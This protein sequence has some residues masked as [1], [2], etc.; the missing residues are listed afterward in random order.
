MN[1]HSESQDLAYKLS[2]NLSRLLLELGKDYQRRILGRLHERG[3]RLFR[4]SHSSVFSNLGLGAVRVTELAERAQ[5]TQQAMGKMLKELERIGYI[6]RDVDSE[7]KRAKQIRLTERG[8]QL[9]KDSMEVVDEVR[10]EYAALVGEDDLDALE[11]Q[12]ADVIHRIKLDYL[13]ESW[14]IQ[15]RD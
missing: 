2:N 14:I 5:V 10:A 9:L 6:V 13:P 4:P 12:L 3:H 7:D 15:E 8:V 1:A 11:S